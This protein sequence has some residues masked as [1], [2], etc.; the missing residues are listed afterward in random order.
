MVVRPRV[1]MVLAP[2]QRIVADRPIGADAEPRFALLTR[3]G[4]G[5]RTMLQ[6]HADLMEASPRT[7]PDEDGVGWY[8]QTAT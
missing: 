7:P 2:G 5:L 4:D 3:D 6:R 1:S 8:G